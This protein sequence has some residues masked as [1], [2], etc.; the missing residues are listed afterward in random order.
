MTS[1]ERKDD[2][3][4][5][6]E[7]G[8]D[9]LMVDEAHMFKNLA[10]FSKMNR[11]SGISSSGSKRAMDMLLKCQY[12]T[13]ING[14]RGVVFATG[15]PVS[16]TMV[17][18]YVMQ[19]FLQQDALEQM[20]I[21]HFDSWAANFG[22]VT[23]ALELT[24]EGS[25]F[26]FKSRFNKFTNLPELMNIFKEVADVQTR[27]M[28]DLDVPEL[29]DHAYQIVSSEPDAYVED[30]MKSFVDRAEAIRGGMVDPS[31]DNF[32]KI[33]HEARLLGTDARLLY[34]DAPDNPDGKLNKAVE[35]IYQEYAD[36]NRD[37]NTAC[38]LVFS[39]IGTPKSVWKEEMLQEDYWRNLAGA[40]GKNR[41]EFDVY[42]YIKT[43][44]VRKGIPAGEIAFI[45]DAAT[46]AQREELFHDMRT[47]KK[48][49]L[50]GSTDKCGTGVNVQ[51]HLTA[52]HHIDCPWKPSSIEQ[53]EGRGIRQGNENDAVAVYRYVTKGTF[54]AYSWSLVENKQRFIS[55]IMTSKAVSRTCEDIDE[56][57][58]SYAEIKAVATG[59]PLIKE[60][61]ELD[62]DVQRLKLLKASY[63]SQRYGL[64]DAFLKRFPKLIKAAEEKL[65][66]VRQD[67][68]ARDRALE[69]QPD[70]SLEVDGVRYAQRP[71]AG[72]A[73][74]AAIN[75]CKSGV[76]TGVGKF[77]GFEVQVEKNFM[78]A[79][80]LI[81]QGATS[82]P[83]ELSLSPIGNVT[84]LENVFNGMQESV[85][86]LQG[87]IEEHTR[88]MEQSKLEYEKP[89]AH[90]EELRAKTARQAELD[91]EL[92][93]ENKTVEDMDLTEQETKSGQDADTREMSPA[94]QT[95]DDERQERRGGISPAENHDEEP[96]L[97]AEDNPYQR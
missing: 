39:D 97:V 64:Q 73:L 21:Y 51:T 13:E 40:D 9:S 3:L 61:M 96:P 78:G 2:L 8:I 22:E 53:R 45:H 88:S 38:Q 60:K 62:N 36:G 35:N 10:V 12:I 81:L 30:V 37:G 7:L 55:Q 24:V 92:D 84:R 83:C 65:A 5:F 79:N 18:L 67:I 72:T 15:T 17:E 86:F 4:T 77:K 16:N 89:F 32:L 90:E 82:H 27:D 11:V 48:K 23:T 25:G 41:G 59:N 28:L 46:D 47:G 57:T 63:D 31:V 54:D 14:G 87:K 42:N 93:L 75:K 70:F 76:T 52:M 68:V 26:R 1:E 20:G 49:I 94:E 33:T 74:M 85:E 44:L 56:A 69:S 6:E 29:K 66:L 71:E 95:T 91:A 19:R 50:I 58:L 43:E 80:Y 34:P